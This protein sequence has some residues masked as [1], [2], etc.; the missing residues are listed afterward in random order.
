MA[1]GSTTIIIDADAARFL[2]QAAKASKA[3]QK[4][5][6]DAKGIGKEMSYAEDVVG[7]LFGTLTKVGAATVA[8]GSAG[9]VV[10]GV[11]DNWLDRLQKALDLQNKLQGGIQGAANA[12]G[13][14]DTARLRSQ[15]ANLGGTLGLETRSKVAATYARAAPGASDSDIIAAVRDADKASQAG[16][17]AEEFASARASLRGLGGAAGDTAAAVLAGGGEQSGEIISLLSD[18]AN[19]LSPQQAQQATP[20]LL[21]AARTPGGVGLLRQGLDTFVNNGL[22]GDFLSQF[23]TPRTGL[24]P[25]IGN[26]RTLAATQAAIRAGVGPLAGLD[27]LANTANADPLTQGINIDAASRAAQE[28]ATL[29]ERSASALRQQAD[30]RLRGV[31]GRDLPEFLR[32]SFLPSAIATVSPDLFMDPAARAEAGRYRQSYASAD[33][34]EAGGLAAAIEEN[35]RALRETKRLSRDNGEP[36]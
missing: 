32:P 22:Q 11:Y 23:M 34:L 25:G 6:E 3:T 12:S 5:A 15:L 7:E 9:K 28:S 14:T 27:A 26:A 30:E 33:Q 36:R 13:S 18:I 10:T 2:A 20:A 21:A 4:I 24:V 31:Y 35:T 29:R 1:D 8:I 19:K 17:N 16:I